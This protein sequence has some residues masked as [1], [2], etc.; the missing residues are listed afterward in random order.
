MGNRQW[1]IGKG[2]R[3]EAESRMYWA[4]DTAEGIK[5]LSLKRHQ[6]DSVAEYEEAKGLKTCEGF[7][8]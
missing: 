6:V 4:F 3:R 1:A 2:W 8:K 7:T 5:A